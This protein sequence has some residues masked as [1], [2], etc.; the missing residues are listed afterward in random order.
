[1]P[2]TQGE[3]DQFSQNV[4]S[5]VLNATNVVI[6]PLKVYT[7]SDLIPVVSTN[8]NRYFKVVTKTL[9]LTTSEDLFKLVPADPSEIV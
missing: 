2:I 7:T 8:G 9:E 5:P 6:E 1:M 4:I 3:R